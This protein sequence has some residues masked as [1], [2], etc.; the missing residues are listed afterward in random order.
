LRRCDARV[1]N[2]EEIPVRPESRP[3][4]NS[5]LL[6]EDEPALL[7]LYEGMLSQLGLSVLAAASPA[8]AMA[9]AAT[10]A[11]EIDLVMTDVVMPEMSGRDLLARIHTT[12]PGLSCL[13]ISGYNADVIS[14]RGVLETG[15]HF[16]QKPFT[17]A[18]LSEKLREMAL[19]DI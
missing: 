7:E 16:L 5:V 12:R 18:A 1:G 4:V 11:T 9:I 8:E 17:L 3:E 15:V 6:V 14:K 10:A 13:Y 2:E 19:I